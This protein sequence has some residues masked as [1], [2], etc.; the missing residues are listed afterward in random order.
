MITGDKFGKWTF[1]RSIKEDGKRV[2]HEA[3]CSCGKIKIHSSGNL[4]KSHGCRSCS[5]TINRRKIGDIKDYWTITDIDNSRIESNRKLY[6]IICKCGYETIKDEGA[7][8]KSKSCRTCVKHLSNNT[9]FSGF[10]ELSG[11]QWGQILNNANKRNIEVAISIE[12]AYALYIKQNKKCALSN[13]DIRLGYKCT[14][15]RPTAS[16]DRIDSKKGYTI[17]NIQWVYKDINLMKWSRDNDSFIQICKAVAEN[18][19]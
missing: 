19:K 8:R 5:R 10:K 14:E 7:L 16:L 12:E 3:V 11:D 6:K 18:N 13:I 4:K 17:D 9:K 15:G 2:K 1:I